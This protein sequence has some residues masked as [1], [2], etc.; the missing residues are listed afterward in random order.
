MSNH[1]FYMVNACLLI[2]HNSTF[3]IMLPA[4]HR[5]HLSFNNQSTLISVRFIPQSES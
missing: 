4:N 3:L 2:S 5:E 1:I